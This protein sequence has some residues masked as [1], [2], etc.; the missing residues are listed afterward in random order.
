MYFKLT[1]ASLVLG[2]R[3]PPF[4]IP[5]IRPTT[6]TEIITSAITTTTVQNIAVVT[7]TVISGIGTEQVGNASNSTN[8][9]MPLIIG[10]SVVGGII[11][12]VLAAVLFIKQKPLK[13][14][15]QERAIWS[16]KSLRDESQESPFKA[17]EIRGFH[18]ESNAA[19]T[20]DEIIKRNSMKAFGSSIPPSV[21]RLSMNS[22]ALVSEPLQ[23]VPSRRSS[24]NHSNRAFSLSSDKK[25]TM[26]AR[27]SFSVF[28]A[29]EATYSNPIT[30]VLPV[31]KFDMHEKLH[32][33]Q[34]CP[35]SINPNID[36][37]YYHNRFGGPTNPYYYES[38]GDIVYVDELGYESYRIVAPST[39]V[40]EIMSANGG[41]LTEPLKANVL[42][43]DESPACK[44]EGY[45]GA[46]VDKQLPRLM[47]PNVPS[48][49]EA[50][51]NLKSES[52]ANNVE[53]EYM[54]HLVDKTA[55]PT[56]EEAVESEASNSKLESHETVHNPGD[57]EQH[58]SIP[59]S[60]VISQKEQ[61]NQSDVKT[62]TLNLVDIGHR[63]SI[64][65]F[66][67]GFN[68]TTD[69]EPIPNETNVNPNPE[70][71]PSLLPELIKPEHLYEDDI[72]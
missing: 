57:I 59:I 15:V 13:E 66:S 40:N 12:T 44:P 64:D 19:N 52:P 45:E 65:Y 62:P 56:V 2:Q 16:S 29:S 31:D 72:Q 11:L 39:L 30:N 28:G 37:Y 53:N 51:S 61:L 24:L 55:V 49:V 46:H 18:S 34:H 54:V 27:H 63:T 20:Y 10:G 48:I 38:N 17:V 32:Y 42:V 8:S 21:G 14:N 36:G 47:D 23:V 4:P 3:R 6:T 1:F 35:Q 22:P 68:S 58:N 67:L 60:N 43:I 9:T 5:P 41:E 25:P 50:N 26:L 33:D 71:F 69:G 70:E 7:N